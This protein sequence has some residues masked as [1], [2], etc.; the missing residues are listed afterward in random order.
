MSIAATFMGHNAFA[1]GFSP[2]SILAAPM[3]NVH[4]GTSGS[5]R[6]GRTIV[7]R[8]IATT[9]IK[10]MS[11]VQFQLFLSENASDQGKH[12]KCYFHYSL[13][14]LNVGSETLRICD[15]VSLWDPTAV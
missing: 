9:G 4:G 3:V 12:E 8:T 13:S 11:R 15:A 2:A 6:A 5:T 1:A 10:R 14:S 7:L